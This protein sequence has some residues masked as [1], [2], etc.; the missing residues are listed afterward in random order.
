MSADPVSWE[1]INPHPLFSVPTRQT[2]QIS[3]NRVATTLR[4]SRRTSWA[5]LC[6]SRFAHKSSLVCVI[7]YSQSLHHVASPSLQSIPEQRG[8]LSK[9][10]QG[11][12]I[13][14]TPLVVLEVPADR[15]GMHAHCFCRFLLGI[16]FDFHELGGARWA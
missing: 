3:L 12:G 2:Q 6:L 16:A 10:G 1:T 5:S 4:F 11:S 14:R 9:V 7:E 15:R 13:V 8:Q